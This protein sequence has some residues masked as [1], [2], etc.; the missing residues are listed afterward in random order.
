M[1]QSLK[2]QATGNVNVLIEGIDEPNQSGSFVRQGSPYST[3]FNPGFYKANIRWTS[4][5]GDIISVDMTNSNLAF[6]RQ[7]TQGDEHESTNV[8]FTIFS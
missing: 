4:N 8:N 1:S 5:A 2:I 3:D 7:V 6:L